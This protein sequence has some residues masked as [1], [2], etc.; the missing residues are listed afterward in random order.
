MLEARLAASDTRSVRN[1][2]MSREEIREL[3]DAL[4]GLLAILREADPADKLEVY[5]Q[6][7]LKLT[8]NHDKRVV[9]AETQPQP[10]VC[11]VNVSEGDLHTNH[12]DRGGGVNGRF[13]VA[14]RSGGGVT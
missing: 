10:P 4:G 7:G 6:L 14:C 2:R 5:R 1:R 9:V 3:V 11:A 13:M 8:Y 12:T